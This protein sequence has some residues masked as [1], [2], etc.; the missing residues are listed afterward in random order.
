MHLDG[1]WSFLRQN[2]QNGCLSSTDERS[3]RLYA[4]EHPHLEEGGRVLDLE[5]PLLEEEEDVGA[6]PFF[7]PY[8]K[9]SRSTR[10]PKIV[11]NWVV[12]QSATPAGLAK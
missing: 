5:F 12:V 1:R 11:R 2:L 3:L 8:I 4:I 9:A 6:L 7:M 10:L